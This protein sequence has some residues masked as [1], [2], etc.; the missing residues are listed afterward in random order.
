MLDL[1]GDYR[2]K[3]IESLDKLKEIAEIRGVS[4]VDL[5]TSATLERL[6]ENA[7]NLVVFGE[8]KRGKSTFINSLLGKDVLPSAVV[9]LTSVITI[10]R[11]SKNEEVIVHFSGW[12]SKN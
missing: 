4:G 8:F 12:D 7:F 6:R 11:Y 3:I 9:P 2:F 10:V 5:S 1:Y